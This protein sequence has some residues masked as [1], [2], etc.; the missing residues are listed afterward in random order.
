MAN[1]PQPKAIRDNLSKLVQVAKNRNVQQ[2][3]ITEVQ[4]EEDALDDVE[5]ETNQIDISSGTE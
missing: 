5:E 1:T 2:A 4:V 3:T